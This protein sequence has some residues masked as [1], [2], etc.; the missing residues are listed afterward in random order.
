MALPA[1]ILVTSMR[2]HQKFFAL[3]ATGEARNLA[4][5][6]MTVANR[7]AD[8]KTDQLIAAGNER[9]LRARLSD[10]RFFWDQDMP[11]AQMASG[12]AKITFMKGWATWP[13]RPGE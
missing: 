11:L 9:V 1:E 8:A 12:L 13:T 6:F 10:A 5:C 7:K 4:P 3:S 2:V